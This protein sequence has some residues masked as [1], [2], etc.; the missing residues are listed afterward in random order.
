MF[1]W[2]WYAVDMVDNP[3]LVVYARSYIECINKIKLIGKEYLDVNI[4]SHDLHWNV[5]GQWGYI[6]HLFSDKLRGGE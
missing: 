5:D 3:S 2:N 1:K 4:L 6:R